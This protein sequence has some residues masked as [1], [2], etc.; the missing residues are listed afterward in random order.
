MNLNE[1]GLGC[2]DRIHL[3]SK[4]GLL[5]TRQWTRGFLDARNHLT[6]F[7]RSPMLPGLS[8]PQ[9]AASRSDR[10]VLLA[11]SLAVGTFYWCDNMF[12]ANKF[13]GEGRGSCE[14]RIQLKGTQNPFGIRWHL[15]QHSHDITVQL[16]NITSLWFTPCCNN[17]RE[18][19]CGS[20]YWVLMSQFL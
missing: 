18:T 17:W 7:W 4:N 15:I 12:S 20:L 19:S 1:I 11:V 8:Y 14:Q 3:T 13:A 6:S 10:S 5:W 16:H 9:S 2:L